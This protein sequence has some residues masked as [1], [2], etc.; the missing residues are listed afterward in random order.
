MQCWQCLLT[1]WL[2]AQ[3][4]TCACYMSVLVPFVLLISG[5][6]SHP[7]GCWFELLTMGNLSSNAPSRQRSVQASPW[8]P[9]VPRQSVPLDWPA[10]PA[11]RTFTC[12]VRNHPP[13]KLGGREES[14]GTVHLQGR[15]TC[16]HGM[17]GLIESGNIC[18]SAV[19]YPALIHACWEWP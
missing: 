7:R 5:A 14:V 17:R 3:Q 4:S 8:I 2:L 13:T 11:G 6:S 12:L 19:A 18:A 16:A 1:R 15:A 10:A 9:G